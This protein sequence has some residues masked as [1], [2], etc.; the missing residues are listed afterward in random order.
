MQFIKV[1]D[2]A[3][4]L[5]VARQDDDRREFLRYMILSKSVLRELK[6]KY[7]NDFVRVYL[8]I[9]QATMTVR[10]PL[11]FMRFRTISLIEEC[12]DNYGNCS[13]KVIPLTHNPYINITPVPTE[14][15]N[16]CDV[17][18]CTP[19]H[20]VCSELSNYTELCEE[21]MIDP[22][23]SP[24]LTGTKQTVLRTCANGDIIKEVTQ[25]VLKF[26]EGDVICDYEI[27]LEI[28]QSICTYSLNINQHFDTPATISF[29]VNGEVVTSGSLLSIDAMNAYMA[30][31]PGWTVV[32]SLVYT[33]VGE[34][35][36]GSTATV[37][38]GGSTDTFN[39]TGTCYQQN[40]LTFPYTIVN[41]TV[42]GVVL[43]ESPAEID[44]DNQTEQDEFFADLGFTKVFNTDSPP[45]AYYTKQ[46]SE[47]VYFNI[48]VDIP[49]SPPDSP[50]STNQINFVQSNCHRFLVSD[51]ISSATTTDV[52]C[53]VP[54]HE[55]CACIIETP[56]T[57]ETICGCCAPYLNCC[58]DGQ[59]TGYNGWGYVPSNCPTNSPQPYNKKGTYSI[60]E[61]NYIIYLDSV[62]ASKVLLAYDN[63]GS[64]DGEYMFPAYLLDAFKAGLAFYHI[65]YN[66]DANPR[67]RLELKMNYQEEL[68]KLSKEY[69]DPIYMADLIGALKTGK[70][71]Y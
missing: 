50:P 54:V 18:N 58:Q 49:E 33:Y 38:G 71:P 22:N 29:T 20:P 24:P 1:S 30:N 65:Q 28:L 51:G 56:T 5:S 14:A 21:V 25:P 19:T 66:E 11:D 62:C 48:V 55:G 4:E 27:V 63:D 41:Y 60:D 57:I 13:E 15:L 10:L 59:L 17:C 31:L 43:S 26:I 69:T 39:I 67:R 36:H 53:N 34:D 9:D 2:V 70:T 40:I 6:L 32:S 68:T 35:V 3:N 61:V 7:I 37:V 46:D 47:D 52:L 44:I 8:P 12:R 23:D 64:C 42:N 16:S 45:V